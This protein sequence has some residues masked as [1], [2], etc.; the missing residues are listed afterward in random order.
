MSSNSNSNSNI[1]YDQ[2]SEREETT[3]IKAEVSEHSQ[4]VRNIVVTYKTLFE[5]AFMFIESTF[6]S[7]LM[8]WIFKKLDNKIDDLNIFLYVLIMLS[9]YFGLLL[10]YI[11]VKFFRND[12]WRICFNSQ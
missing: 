11:L 8:L 7:F 3:E 4:G 9:C 6:F 1:D 5:N 12:V 2:S 10:P